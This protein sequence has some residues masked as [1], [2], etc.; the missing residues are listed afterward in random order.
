M[1]RDVSASISKDLQN[2]LV[3][4]RRHVFLGEG[5]EGSDGAEL[6]R[7]ANPTDQLVLI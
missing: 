6:K 1:V 7:V 4:H 3:R 2:T 5:S